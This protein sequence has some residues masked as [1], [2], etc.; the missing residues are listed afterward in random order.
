MITRK[1]YLSNGKELFDK[2][3]GQFV[4]KELIELVKNIFG[5]DELIN[6]Y[7]ED[8]PLNN[9]PLAL[10]DR[11]LVEHYID[12]DKFKQINGTYSLS[13]RVC[14]AKTAAN[15][16]IFEERPDLINYHKEN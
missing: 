16:A 3:Y 11:I 2:Y 12:I 15:Q 13:D 4:T 10:W 1:E 5:I 7:Q 8:R 9:I 14:L 6:A